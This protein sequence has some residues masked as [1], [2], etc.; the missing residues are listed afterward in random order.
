MIMNFKISDNYS[1]VVQFFKDEGIG[2]QEA[3]RLANQ[4]GG[5]KALDELPREEAL[6]RAQD[7][8]ENYEEGFSP[9]F[10]LIDFD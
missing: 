2:T 3:I 9:W 5:R 4:A 8:Y 1:A 10:D 7:I 6:G